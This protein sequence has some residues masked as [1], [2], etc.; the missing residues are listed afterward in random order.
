MRQVGLTDWPRHRK[1]IAAP[2]NENTNT[3]V[4]TESISQAR[5]MLVSWVKCGR[6]GTLGLAQDTRTLS[7]NVL[8]ATGFRRSYK[9]YRATEATTPS[10]IEPRSYQEALSIILENTLLIMVTPPKLLFLPFVPKSWA[11]IGQAIS[12]FKNY[13]TEMLNH[14]MSLLKDGKSGTGTLMTSLV[15]ASGIDEKDI[16]CGGNP[17]G[18]TVSEVLGNIFFINFAGHDTTANSLSYA[19][20]LLSA[21]PEVQTW[22]SEEIEKLTDDECVTYEKAFPRLKRCQAVLVRSLQDLSVE[23]TS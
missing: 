13:I 1:I 12:E 21:H 10:K 8:A 18:L 5:E 20:L 9:F 16:D 19:L 23:A 15:R 17:K 6:T 2:F 7:L 4:W 3:L 22:V 11:V 14:E